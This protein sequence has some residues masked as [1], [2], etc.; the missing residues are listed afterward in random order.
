MRQTSN[1]LSQHGFAH[2]FFSRRGGVS[3]GS[4]ATLNFAASTGD[5]P[6]RVREN[7]SRA[8]T[9]LGIGPERLYF[10]SQVHGTVAVRLTGT[11]ARD[12]VVRMEGDAT[13]STA[14]GVAC[15][16]S[17]ADCG[18]ILIGDRETGAVLAI[19]AG[20][21]GTEIGVVESAVFALRQA[22]GKEGDLI[23]AIG[24]HIEVCCFEVGADVAERLARSSSL[25]EGA[26]DRL[27]E[28]PHVDLRRILEAKLVALGFATDAIDHVRGC[29]VCDAERFF[30]Y[31]RDGKLSGRLLSAIVSR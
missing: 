4:Y 31:R 17:S 26:V 12:D 16:V 25:G 22:L 13:F 30:S 29:T 7:V 14:R 2:G 9:E 27:S 6:D 23:A 15:G 11:E 19:H 18:T 24:P 1:L 8:A 21:R 5:D 10:L 28:K 20:W 3:E